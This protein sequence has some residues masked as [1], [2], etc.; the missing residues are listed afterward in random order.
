MAIR[1]D[2]ALSVLHRVPHSNVYANEE[3]AIG[4]LVERRN[5]ALIVVCHGRMRVGVAL[6]IVPEIKTRT[7]DGAWG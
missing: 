3:F 1:I 7:P 6:A 2:S 5:W 4:F